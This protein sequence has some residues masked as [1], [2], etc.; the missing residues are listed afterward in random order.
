MIPDYQQEEVYAALAELADGLW[1]DEHWEDEELWGELSEES[2]PPA[3]VP[4]FLIS[5]LAAIG[6]SGG[7]HPEVVWD[8]LDD[9]DWSGYLGGADGRLHLHPK[10]TDRPLLLHELAHWCDNRD[11]HGPQFCSNYLDLIDAVLGPAACA[12][13]A[14]A[15]ERHGVEVEDWGPPAEGWP[16]GAST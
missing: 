3:E 4:A 12:V 11:G 5:A 9:S 16:S 15:F 14:A 10:L 2:I 8:V 13:L 7:P 1:D 6:S